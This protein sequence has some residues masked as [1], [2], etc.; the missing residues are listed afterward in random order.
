MRSGGRQRPK[1]CF[2]VDADDGPRPLPLGLL[3]F[4][5]SCSYLVA[6]LD[7]FDEILPGWQKILNDPIRLGDPEAFGKV[8]RETG[9]LFVL[10]SHAEAEARSLT[11]PGAFGMPDIAEHPVGVLLRP[12]WLALC[13]AYDRHTGWGDLLAAEA[14]VVGAGQAAMLDLWSRFGFGPV[15]STLQTPDSSPVL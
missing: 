8:A 3:G 9:R 5:D 6:A 12:A 14:D 7:G 15:M 13:D 4:I 10:L 1:G 11:G 2:T